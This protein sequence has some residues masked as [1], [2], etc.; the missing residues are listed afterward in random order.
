MKNGNEEK[1]EQYLKTGLSLFVEMSTIKF[2]GCKKKLGKKKQAIN[3]MLIF[4]C[5]GN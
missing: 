1:H 4:N 5:E 3:R 2:N